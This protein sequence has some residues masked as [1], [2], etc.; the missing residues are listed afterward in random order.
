MMQR[1]QNAPIYLMIGKRVIGSRCIPCAIYKHVVTHVFVSQTAR[2]EDRTDGALKLDV[3]PAA[4]EKT[5]VL[6]IV[7][8]TSDKVRFRPLPIEADHVCQSGFEQDWFV[9]IT[10]IIE[11][12]YP[13]H[14]L[15]SHTFCP[16]A[17]RG[18]DLGFGHRLKFSV[19]H[20]LFG[21]INLKLSC[22]IPP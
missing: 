13:V 22:P 10:K 11:F 8:V 4:L 17:L 15:I 3:L 6:Q 21:L 18:H 14:V 19:S 12:K 20:L 1:D 2:L 5:T 9:R 7:G 16:S